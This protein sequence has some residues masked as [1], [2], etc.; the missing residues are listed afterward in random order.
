VTT[1]KCLMVGVLSGIVGVCAAQLVV[2]LA[3]VQLGLVRMNADA[4]PPTWEARVAR[5]AVHA[6]IARYA[7][8]QSNPLPAT[9]ENLVA[10]ARIYQE[11][12]AKCHGKPDAGPSVFGSS[13]YPPAPGLQGSSTRYTDAELFWIVKHGIRNTAM[14]AWGRL[15]SDQ[16]IWQVVGAVKR[17]NEGTTPQKSLRDLH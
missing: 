13:F 11:A 10:G 7:T 12:C 2:A 16:D 8:E 6:S 4:P 3:G 1:T 14:P 15:L 5:V 17:G 9:D